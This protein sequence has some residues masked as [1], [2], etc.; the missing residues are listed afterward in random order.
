[1]EINK[2]FSVICDIAAAGIIATTGVLLYENKKKKE[3]ADLNAVL[4]L[5]EIRDDAQDI[6]IDHCD[7]DIKKLD[8]RID[9]LEKSNKK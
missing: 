8:E 2:I 7:K 1:M 5:L 9:L 4:K 3:K 6:R